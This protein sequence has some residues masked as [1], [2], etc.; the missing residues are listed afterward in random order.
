[1]PVAPTEHRTIMAVDAVDP[2]VPREQL[3]RLPD[4]HDSLH[5]LLQRA[6]SRIGVDLGDGEIEDRG[7][8]ALILVLP[9]TVPKSTLADKLP[10]QL[11]VE[12]LRYDA[13]RS[14]GERIKLRVAV[15][16]GEIRKNGSGWA[17]Q[18]VDLASRLLDV[19]EAG[20]AL[21]RTDGAVAMIASDHFYSEVIRQNPGTASRPYRRIDA[22]DDSFLE[23]AWLWLPESSLPVS[24]SEVVSVLDLP[25][26]RGVRVSAEELVVAGRSAAGFDEVM[27][28]LT[29]ALARHRIVVLVGRPGTG[30]RSTALHALSQFTEGVHRLD[31]HD[32]YG[33]HELLITAEFEPDQGYLFDQVTAWEPIAGSHLVQLG[34]LLSTVGAYA[35]IA[36]DDVSERAAAD[37][38]PY[39]V[40]ADSTPAVG[41]DV[42]WS[43]DAP[44]Q[45]DLLKRDALAKVL[46]DRIGETRQRHEDTSLLVHLD[47][48]W[49]SGKSSLLN[50]LDKCLK[51]DFLVVRFD[52][53][54][55]S[56]LSPPWW[57]L[58]TTT[59]QAIVDDRSWWARHWLRLKETCERARQSGAPF[60]LAL[61]LLLVGAVG[62]GA[63]VQLLFGSTPKIDVLRVIGPVT[64]AVLVVWTGAKVA[65]RV[66][67]WNSARGARLFE[68]SDSNPLH[69]VT[70]HFGWLLGQSRRPVVFFIDDL[71]RCKDDYVVELLETVQTLVRD[72][73]QKQAYFVVSAD[74]VWLRKSFACAY[75]AFADGDKA[76]NSIG[77]QFLDKLFQL[78]V[79][80]PALS[81]SAQHGFLGRL[82]DLAE[83]AASD[84]VAAAKAKLDD[85][86]G[87][88]AQ[89]LETLADIEDPSV[90][91]AV[92]AHAALAVDEVKTRQ[93]TEHQLLKFAPLLTPNPRS[94]KLFLNTYS[95]LRAVRTLEAITVD[96]DTLALWS[97]LRVCYPSIADHLQRNPAAVH[98]IRY[99][100]W[101]SECFPE[102]LQETAKSEGLRLIV[103]HPQGGPLTPELIR[104]CCGAG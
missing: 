99:P 88:E 58:L 59:R 103:T 2:E 38:G 95:M 20:L 69:R 79:P 1:M 84:A 63:I 29:D 35:V 56:R 94:T 65:S 14:G 87:S 61:V 17:G 7:D 53:W 39:L 25:Q 62:I 50:L 71:D 31:L 101:R 67:L 28:R 43:T 3:R 80:M 12:V 54:Q 98:G 8:G 16:A 90:R 91:E 102:E 6:F 37:I 44:A 27:A 96:A 76:H 5:Y 73:R 86:K 10:D 41:T 15:H 34:S 11:V 18:P 4:L 82:L 49:G 81:T 100:P 92:A 68:Q 72:T 42:A 97:I 57:A 85:A 75:G 89:I 48:V 9:P 52:A 83:P 26:A 33:L 22:S 51:N 60:I 46:A 45:V 13:T 21:W 19:Q 104:Q 30:R 36:L 40:R 77:Y 74:G 70:R 47:G 32:A 78:S 64:T 24:R 23:P 93:A 66:L 55:Q